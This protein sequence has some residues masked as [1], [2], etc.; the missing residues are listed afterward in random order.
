MDNSTVLRTTSL[1]GLTSS[2]F[3]SGIYFCSTQLALPLLHNLPIETSTPRFAQLYHNGAA[4]VG[5]LVAL[6]SLSLG[7]SAYLDP[8]KRTQYAIAGAVVF[9]S[10][11][12]TRFVMWAGIQRLIAISEDVKLQQKVSTEEVAE[13]FG[14]WGWMNLVRSGMAGIGGVVGLLLAVDLL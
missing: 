3:L 8:K 4:V 11:P 1:I 6:S 2:L 14:Q 12:W 7:T 13:L 9:A 5:P 10:L